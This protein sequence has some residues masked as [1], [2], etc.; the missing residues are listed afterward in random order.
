MNRRQLLQN[1]AALAA[2]LSYARSSFAQATPQPVRIGII[3]MGGRGNQLL[4]EFVK[5]PGVQVGA[6]VDPDGKRVEEAA[7]WVRSNTG[8]T[9]KTTADMRTVF[10]DKAIDAVLVATPNHWHALT[11][12]WAM[13]A[14][15]DVYLEKPVSHNIFEG[16]KILEASRKYKRIV[17]GGTQRRS[18]GRFR[19]AVRLIH[20]G[21]IGDVYLGKWVFP[22]HRDSIGFKPI[23]PVPGWLNWD[24]WLG[25]AQEQP[26]HANL[27]HYNWH[28]FW[29]FGNGELGNNGPHLIDISRWAMQKELPTKIRSWGGRWGYKDQAETPNTQ[30]VEW[31][32]DDGT[33]I[34]AELR[35]LYTPEPMSWDFFGSKGSMHIFQDGRF[36]VTLGRKEK[37]EPQVESPPDINH[38]ANFIEAVRTR[39]RSRQNAEIR[40]TVLSTAYCHLGN[41]AYRVGGELHFDTHTQRFL[42]NEEANGLISRRYR[43]PY[44]VPENV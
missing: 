42:N 25:P 17:Q 39:D 10:D 35:G 32:F 6:V 31:E 8:V 26:Y 38:Y 15:K 18:F 1:S 16:Q 7:Q 5:V 27:V 29:D 44:I 3:G 33:A 24:L 40:E 13:Q 34:I 19:H 36:E 21:L 4:R 12:I 28:W 30:S 43:A 14:G 37:P 2:G 22:G 23:E 11:A 9:P 20:E 41:I